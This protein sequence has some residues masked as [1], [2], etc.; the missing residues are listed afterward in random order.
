MACA[1]FCLTLGMF[2]MCLTL[3][4]VVCFFP[5]RGILCHSARIPGYGCFALL[6][7]FFFASSLRRWRMVVSVCP[8][9]SHCVGSDED[10]LGTVCD[11]LCFRR[12][13]VA[14]SL[15]W[16]GDR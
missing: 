4:L 9:C 10:F 7:F 6:F 11:R 3:A 2:L 12:A 5:E 14:S 13:C 16:I 1:Y 15:R 8:Y